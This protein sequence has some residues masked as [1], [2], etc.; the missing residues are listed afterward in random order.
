MSEDH[1]RPEIVAAAPAASHM[2]DLR[3]RTSPEDADMGRYRAKRVT[4]VSANKFPAPIVKP[5]KADGK[6]VSDSMKK[7]NTGKGEA[8]GDAC[9]R[10]GREVFETAEVVA[11]EK[12]KSGR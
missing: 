7:K 10:S 12:E 1:A 6:T 11:R 2:L 8:D 4:R 5:N 3:R 9:A